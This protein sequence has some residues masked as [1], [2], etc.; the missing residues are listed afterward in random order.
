M[1]SAYKSRLFRETSNLSTYI[2]GQVRRIYEVI[3]DL[4]IGER[5]RKRRGV[6]TDIL[7]RV[8]GFASKDDVQ[9]VI[10]ILEQ[11]QTGVYEAAKL[12]D[13]GIRS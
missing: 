13:Q 6:M 4:S 7:S 5:D 3:L 1:F 10:H 2:Q 8:T 12:W 11:I 9:A